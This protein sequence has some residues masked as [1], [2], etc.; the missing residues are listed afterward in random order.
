MPLTVLSLLIPL[1][2]PIDAQPSSDTLVLSIDTSRPIYTMRGGIGASWHA[3]SE[4]LPLENEKYDYPVRVTNPR[5][6]AYG[7]NPPPSAKPLWDQLYRHATWLGLDWV[8]VEVSLRMWEPE[9]GVFHWNGDEMQALYRILDWCEKNHADVFLQNMWSNVEWNA[10]PGVH[11]ILSAPRDIQAFADGMARLIEH[12]TKTRGYTC[13]KWFCITNEPPGGT[14]GYWWSTGS[15][16]QITITPAL[17]A[18]RA[19]FDKRGL[20]IPLS[21]PDWTDLPRL[22]PAKIDFDPFVGAYDIHSYQGVD[23]KRQALLAE[24]TRFAHDRGK[25]FFLSEMGNMQLG[26]GDANPGPKTFAASLS[27][28]ETI[29]RGLAAG[30][31]AFNRWSYTNRGDLDGQWQLVHT[32]DRD[33]KR[34]LDKIEPEPAAYFGY[35]ILTRLI[36]KHSKVLAVQKAVQGVDDERVLAAALLAPDGNVTVILL[37]LERK[38]VGVTV[39]LSGDQPG[40]FFKYQVTASAAEQSGFRLVPE[41]TRLKDSLPPESITVF[42]TFHLKPDAPGR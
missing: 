37:N 15:D 8:R 7:G 12:L 1:I 10:Y 25:P 41:P 28:A 40:S 18:V 17:E 34:Y 5:G 24:W 31:D 32:W 33:N 26:W 22:D 16:P 35:G 20:E 14:W 39:R 38:G 2:M 29:V 36:A 6:S 23:S 21:A 3:M 30:I 11:P 19:A 42:S 13:I 9:K 4:D 27:N